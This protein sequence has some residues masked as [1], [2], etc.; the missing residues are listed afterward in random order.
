MS[1]GVKMI[2]EESK[3][4]KKKK[5]KCRLKA[6]G[7]SNVNTA[8]TGTDVNGVEEELDRG[9]GKEFGGKMYQ[10]IWICDED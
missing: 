6:Q 3:K 5:K 4:K 8:S 9:G 10:R 2:Q 7:D 1:D